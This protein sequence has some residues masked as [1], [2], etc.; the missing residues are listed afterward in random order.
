MLLVRDIVENRYKLPNNVV[1]AL[2]P[3]YNIGGALNRSSN[4]RVDQNGP[5]EFGFRGNSQNYDLNRD[6][7]KLDTKEG[8]TFSKIF[9][10]LDPDI[11]I[12]NHVSN[13]ADYQHVMTLLTSQHNKL[14]GEMGI[15]LNK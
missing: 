8:A 4:Y 13:G 14:G 10:F 12:D 11:F 5:E 6:F 3:I 1:L 9:Q 15:Y 7:I 2:I